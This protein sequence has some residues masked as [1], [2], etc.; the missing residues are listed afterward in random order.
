[1]KGFSEAI[2]PVSHLHIRERWKNTYTEYAIFQDLINFFSFM[3]KKN[4]IVL[5]I[6]LFGL[7]LLI[8]MI[9]ENAFVPF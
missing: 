8:K 1:M 5:E 7:Y 6:S 4:K 3:G 9:I 2:Q